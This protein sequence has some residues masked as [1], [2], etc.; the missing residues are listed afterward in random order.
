MKTIQE[1]R[2]EAARKLGIGG[3]TFDGTKAAIGNLSPAN[4]ER[5]NDEVSLMIL[6]SPGDY[7]SAQ[8]DVAENRVGSALFDRPLERM[9]VTDVVKSAGAGA[10]EGFSEN[11]APQLKFAGGALAFVGKNALLL[12][13]LVGAVVLLP[14]IAPSITAAKKAVKTIKK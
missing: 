7:T 12:S 6:A 1:T 5:L 8:I 9:T 14:I 11:I 3:R 13:L 4:Q 10:K 2:I